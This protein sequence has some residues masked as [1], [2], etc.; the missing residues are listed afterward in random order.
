MPCPMRI[1]IQTK[2]LRNGRIG[3]ACTFFNIFEKGRISG[4]SNRANTSN[5]L[6]KRSVIFPQY[7]GDA[8]K[9]L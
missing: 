5:S 7:Y 1:Q 2:R 6:N 4:G 9:E 3:A 8:V